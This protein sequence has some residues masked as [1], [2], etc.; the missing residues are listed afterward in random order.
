MFKRFAGSG[1]LSRK[2]IMSAK[3]AVAKYHSGRTL[4]K[5]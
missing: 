1:K 3:G 5:H 4:G 2:L